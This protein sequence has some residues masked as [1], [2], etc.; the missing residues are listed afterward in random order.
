MPR[1]V[2]LQDVD[3]EDFDDFAEDSGWNEVEL[4]PETYDSEDYPAQLWDAPGGQV[5]FVDDTV[6]KLQY[7][8]IDTPSSEIERAIR[9]E[10]EVRDRD[11]LLGLLDLTAPADDLS[12]TLRML[13]RAAQATPFDQLIFDAVTTALDNDHEDMQIAALAVAGRSR[14][15]Q[16]LPRVTELAENSESARVRGVAGNARTILEHTRLGHPDG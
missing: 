9:E 11:E 12:R 7:V 1:L 14:W 13:A 16:F 10:F 6:F 2:F 15:T 3:V 5:H 8:D 4:D